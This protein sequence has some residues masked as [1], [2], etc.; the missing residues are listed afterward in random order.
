M[1]NEVAKI[2]CTHTDKRGL[3]CMGC[4]A[5]L[6]KGHVSM[7]PSSEIDEHQEAIDKSK[8][9]MEFKCNSCKKK[10]FLIMF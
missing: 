10:T 1:E 5:F 2:K 8:L 7:C 6:Y 4:Y 3:P 9:V